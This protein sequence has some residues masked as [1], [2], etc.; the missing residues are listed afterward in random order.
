MK[1]M[2]CQMGMIL[3]LLGMMLA[4]GCLIEGTAGLWGTLGVVVLL[5]CAQK[6]LGYA[7]EHKHRRRPSKRRPVGPAHGRM[8]EKH[9]L[10]AA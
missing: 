10:R 5:L 3:C 1:K 9:P 4:V 2:L 8:A 7:A 6:A